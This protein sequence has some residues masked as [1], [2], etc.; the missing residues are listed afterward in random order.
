[1]HGFIGAGTHI[2]NRPSLGAHA[3]GLRG[4]VS[5]PR[6]GGRT[7]PGRRPF[8]AE[9]HPGFAPAAAEGDTEAAC[10]AGTEL[11]PF[12]GIRRSSPAGMARNVTPQTHPQRWRWP[13]AD[14]HVTH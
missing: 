11:L 1:M 14:E 7:Q 8:L 10:E 9:S 13:V 5:D 2:L 12:L 3:G 4:E 6:G